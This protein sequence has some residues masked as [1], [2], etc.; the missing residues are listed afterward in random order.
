MGGRCEETCLQR[1]MPTAS[2]HVERCS[3]SL[4]VGEMEIRGTRSRH[5]TPVGMAVRKKRQEPAR[6]WRRGSPRAPCGRGRRL[7]WPPREP[8]WRRLKK[9][10][11]ELP[12]GAALL[13]L[14]TRPEEVKSP[15]G[16]DSCPPL[17]PTASFPR[18]KAGTQ[19][20]CPLLDEWARRRVHAYNAMSLGRKKEGNPPIW[21]HVQ[22]PGAHHGK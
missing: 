16:T 21:D 12:Y 18:A 3:L 17:F 6:R 2:G 14:G 7:V 9:L 1:R 20:K 8:V 13:L 5:L 19:P 10:K 15:C 22:A 11:T 4:V